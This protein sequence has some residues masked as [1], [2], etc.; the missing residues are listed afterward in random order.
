LFPPPVSGF[1]I[2]SSSRPKSHLPSIRAAL[3]PSHLSRALPISARFRRAAWKKCGGTRK[4]KAAAKRVQ[5]GCNSNSS[6]PLHSQRS[7]DIQDGDLS[8]AVHVGPCQAGQLRPQPRTSLHRY[9]SPPKL[10]L[11]TFL[12]GRYGDSR[13]KESQRRNKG[14]RAGHASQRSVRERPKRQHQRERA[15]SCEPLLLLAASCQA[16]A[17]AHPDAPASGTRTELSTK[18][19][20]VKE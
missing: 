4:K 16:T 8:V 10:S 1:A 6:R 11:R 12:R 14:K 2:V 13:S 19:G 9:G 20:H 5:K 3:S 18:S 15:S 17:T 7:V